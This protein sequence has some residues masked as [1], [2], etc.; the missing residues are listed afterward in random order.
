MSLRYMNSWIAIVYLGL[1]RLE[2]WWQRQGNENQYIIG[3]YIY[4]LT[5]ISTNWGYIECI[6]R[7]GLLCIN[8]NVIVQGSASE[9]KGVLILLQGML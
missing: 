1:I 3:I 2:I 6:L 4:I 7:V 8:F 5:N 9:L